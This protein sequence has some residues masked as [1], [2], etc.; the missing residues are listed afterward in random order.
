V[1]SVPLPSEDNVIS[2]GQVGW[3]GDLVVVAVLALMLFPDLEPLHFVDGLV[4]VV[5]EVD[6][7][8]SNVKCIKLKGDAL[9]LSGLKR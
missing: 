3:D 1:E 4:T 7:A 8:V 2:A 6:K 5:C 9:R